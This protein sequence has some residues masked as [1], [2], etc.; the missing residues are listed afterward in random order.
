MGFLARFDLCEDGA[1]R[2]RFMLLAMN[3]C[4]EGDGVIAGTGWREFI[5]PAERRRERLIEKAMATRP[6]TDRRKVTALVDGIL[7][8]TN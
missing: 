4:L 3:D 8:A 1:R 6:G 7:E 2:M 5:G